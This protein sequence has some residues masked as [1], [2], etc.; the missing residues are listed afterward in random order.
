MWGES[1]RPFW[2]LRRSS[3]DASRHGLMWLAP[4]RA[5]TCCLHVGMPEAAPPTQLWKRL[6]GLRGRSL[7]DNRARCIFRGLQ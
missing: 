7:E 4:R 2:P 3:F 5:G 1:S 6:S